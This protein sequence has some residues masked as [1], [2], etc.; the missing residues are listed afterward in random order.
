MMKKIILCFCLVL[1]MIFST[2]LQVGTSGV[3]VPVPFE[4]FSEDGSRVFVFTPD[5]NDIRSVYAAVYEIIGNERQLVYIV[6]DLPSTVRKEELFF[7]A[8]MMHFVHTFDPRLGLGFETF[9]NGARTRAVARRDIIWRHASTELWSRRGLAPPVHRVQWRIIDHS[10]IDA[11]I[12]IHT[13]EGNIF[14]F[15]FANAEFIAGNIT[16]A[17]ARSRI[18]IAIVVVVFILAALK[19]FKAKQIIKSK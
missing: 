19:R 18:I 8:D 6:E 12:A 16:P 11:T 2:T 3:R 15:D 5:E 9:S 7:S 4:I 1:V 17:R 14:I 10:P 13:D